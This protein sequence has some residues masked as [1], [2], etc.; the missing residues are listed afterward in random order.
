MKTAVITGSVGGAMKGR[1]SQGGVIVGGNT[2]IG[3]ETAAALASQGYNTIIACRDAEKA[4][5]AVERIK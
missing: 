4:N 2:G 1:L 5:T 3:F